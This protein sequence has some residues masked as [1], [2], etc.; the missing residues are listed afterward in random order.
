MLDN[1]ATDTHAEYVI[2]TDFPQQQLFKNTHQYYVHAYIVCLVLCVVFKI[3][4]VRYTPVVGEIRLQRPLIFQLRHE[5][6]TKV[7]VLV[8]L[9]HQKRRKRYSMQ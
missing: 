8:G 2:L 3:K 1:Y 9:K 7:S 4:Q 6:Q 5:K